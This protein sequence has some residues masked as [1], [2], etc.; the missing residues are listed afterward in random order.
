MMKLFRKPQRVEVH[1]FRNKET[2]ERYTLD[3]YKKIGTDI[4]KGDHIVAFYSYYGEL[5]TYTTSEI[6]RIG[7]FR[8]LTQ[9]ETYRY[10]EPSLLGF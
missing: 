2:G 9:K 3:E 4:K 7:R 5:Q 1:Y 10:L 8:F 6:L